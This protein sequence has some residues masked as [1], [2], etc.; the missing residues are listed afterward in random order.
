[1]SREP[2]IRDV[3]RVELGAHRAK[4]R[5]AI[6]LAVREDGWAVV[7]LTTQLHEGHEHVFVGAR[8]RYGAA[9]KLQGDSYIYARNVAVVKASEILG[10]TGG[11]CPPARYDQ[12]RKL[13]EGELGGS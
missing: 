5:P 10:V 8:T 11:V 4:E 12:I 13:C 1:M 2:K 9:L 7:S 3:V 6:L